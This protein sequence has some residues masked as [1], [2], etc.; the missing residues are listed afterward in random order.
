MISEK[1]EYFLEQET[2]KDP[3]RNAISRI[4]RKREQR[5]KAEKLKFLTN[6]R[7]AYDEAAN[8]DGFMTIEQ[9]HNSEL[10]MIIHD[11]SLS[12][13]DFDLLF[14][15]IDANSEGTITWERLIH[16]L[17]KDVSTASAHKSNEAINFIAQFRTVVPKKSQVH[18]D[19]ISTVLI[20]NRTS[21]Y[22]TISADSIRLWKQSDLQFTRVITENVKF[23]TGLVFD[24]LQVLAAA[25]T[26]RRLL[27]YDLNTLDRLPVEINASP[28]ALVIKNMTKKEAISTLDAMG[29]QSQPMYNMPT[30]LHMSEFDFESAPDPLFF[31]GDDMG[32]IEVYRLF[33]PKRRSGV[34][35]SCTRLAK[36]K[37]HDD[38][39]THLAT[40]SSRICY[41]SSSEDHTVKFWSFDSVKKTHQ[42]L[43][44]FRADEPVMSFV[45]SNVQ[46]MLTTIGVSRDAYVW[47]EGTGRKIFKLGGHY[48]A[49]SLIT[50]YVTTSGENYILT[51]TNRKEFRVWDAQNYRLVKEFANRHQLHPEDRY[52]AGVFDPRRK[53]FVAASNQPALWGEDVGGS[54]EFE[55]SLTHS[56]PIIGCFVV[57]EFCQLITVDSLCCIKA[58]NLYDGSLIVTHLNGQDSQSKDVA[59]AILDNSK[60]RLFTSTYRNEMTI[61]NYNSGIIIKQMNL[62]GKLLVSTMAAGRYDSKDILLR[63]GW[64][65]VIYYYIEVE[66]GIF[67]LQR[68]FEGHT[69]DISCL[70]I[71]KDGIVSGTFSGELISWNIALNKISGK[72]EVSSI[73]NLII[74]DNFA[75]IGDSTGFVHVFALPTLEH[76][77]SFFAQD[78]TV[79]TSISALFYDEKTN[80]LFTGDSFGYV[81]QWKVTNDN[82]NLKFDKVGF[83]RLHRDEI[84]SISTTD[85][86]FVITCGIDNCV[87]LW[88]PEFDFVGLYTDES[89]W[90]IDDKETWVIEKPFDVDPKHFQRKQTMKSRIFSSIRSFS[91]LPMIN[92]IES[93]L[94]LQNNEANNEETKQEQIHEILMDPVQALKVLD[95]FYHSDTNLPPLSPIQSL[96]PELKPPIKGPPDLEIFSRERELTEKILNIQKQSDIDRSHFIKTE[97]P[98]PVKQTLIPKKTVKLPIPLRISPLKRKIPKLSKSAPVFDFH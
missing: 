70:A 42:V 38:S 94:K 83:W 13:E 61:W 69:N 44:V 50:N 41:A 36:I 98:K 12:E 21:E 6:L 86:G 32:T 58:H 81:K 8:E 31:I 62:D 59:C 64:D 92:K 28:T 60:R 75:V 30:C 97:P 27:F 1:K 19:M 25:T 7:K 55:E 5:T 48:N 77:D 22:V 80:F 56:R 2:W 96:E 67:E 4:D 18:R 49:I 66:K 90:N 34:D 40:I 89:K 84:T 17:V 79:A 33:A 57:P 74:I 37:I 76:R 11:G 72:V 24:N 20:S 47:S 68:V 51:M 29:S 63:A 54:A 43:Q 95:N 87:R 88:S 9:W 78:L 3:P 16:Y 35:F 71:S 45:Y 65:K 46:K 93:Q 15:K 10:R 73:E 39:V 91:K 26:T 14:K 23:Q 52:S 85:N 82:D 53:V